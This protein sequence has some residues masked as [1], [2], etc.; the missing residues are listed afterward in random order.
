MLSAE[1]KSSISSVLVSHKHIWRPSIK[2]FAQKSVVFESGRDLCN[3]LSSAA[4]GKVETTYTLLFLVFV[5]LGVSVGLAI[6][7]CTLQY[8]IDLQK[9]VGLRGRYAILALEL[10]RLKQEQQMRCDSDPW[11]SSE[12]NSSSPCP[13]LEK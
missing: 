9:W 6:G 7:Y 12:E 11:E 13:S 1:P 3:R 8:S 10:Q 5:I 4:S 2:G